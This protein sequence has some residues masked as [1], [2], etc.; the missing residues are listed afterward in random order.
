MSFNIRIEE[1]NIYRYLK[2][3]NVIQTKVNKNTGLSDNQ[4]IQSI[5]IPFKITNINNIIIIGLGGG[6]LNKEIIT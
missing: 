6:A 5:H 3:N 1:D 2:I 4:Y